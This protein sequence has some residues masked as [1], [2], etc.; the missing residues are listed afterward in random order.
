MGME[1][2][3]MM[4]RIKSRIGVSPC[5]ADADRDGSLLSAR[6]TGGRNVQRTKLFGAQKCPAEIEGKTC[7]RT[8]ESDLHAA[9]FE[10]IDLGNI[11]S[12]NGGYSGTISAARKHFEGCRA[13]IG[14]L[15]EG[16]SKIQDGNSQFL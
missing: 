12:W 11:H 16:K 7:E 9:K 1:I 4:N 15:A 13:A 8:I 3:M 10:R 14:G 2:A 5:A 6:R